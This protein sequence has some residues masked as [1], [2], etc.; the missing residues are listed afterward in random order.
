MVG[1]SLLF[2]LSHSVSL[3]LAVFGV[4]HLDER[5][6]EILIA[7]SIAFIGVENLFTEMLGR[8]R[9]L[10][11]LGF[12]LVHGLGFASVLAGKLKG[13]PREQLAGPLLGF[14]V[15]V[16][17]AQISVLIAAFLVLLPLK[18]WTR[19]VQTVGSVLVAL[20]GIGWMVERMLGW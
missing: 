4:V 18:R 6:V 2:T 10:L 16:E 5:L 17:L 9:V 13:L 7:F 8:R 1:Q 12:G 11:V 14:N 20:T 19:R 15:G 3:A